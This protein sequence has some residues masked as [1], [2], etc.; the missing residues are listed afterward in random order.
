MGCCA[1]PPV[2]IG[3]KVVTGTGTLSPKCAVDA[4]PSDVRS[5]GF[6][7]KRVLESCLSRRKNRLGRLLS[8]MF[9]CVRFRRSRKVNGSG[10]IDADPLMP[11]GPVT[12]GE[13]T[14]R[15]YSSRRVRSTSSSSTS[16]T[17]SGRALSMAE[18]SRPAAA[19]R[20][21]VSLIEMALVAA[22]GATRRRSTTMRSRSSV[23]FRSALL[24]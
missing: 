18:I 24:R 5:C 22:T 2:A 19:T 3:E 15:P 12:L 10:V 11:V 16:I 1:T 17:T 4:M 23:S 6:A 13:A 8:M 14:C 20:S 7:S 21:G 9:D